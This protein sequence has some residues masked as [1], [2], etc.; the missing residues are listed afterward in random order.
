MF[1]QADI[2]QLKQKG[3]VVEQVNQQIEFFRKGIPKL[4]IDR[5]A[6]VDD[7]IIVLN[8]DYLKELIA[9]F[10]DQNS[11]NSVVKFVPASGAA[12]RMFKSLFEQL[13]KPNG[14]ELNTEIEQVLNSLPLFAFYDD[15]IEKIEDHGES[16]SI[17]LDI[18]DIHT[19]LDYILSEKGLNY[20]NLPK[21]L[22]KFHKYPLGNRTAVEEHLVEGAL[23]AKNNNEDV[24]IHFTVSP[25]HMAKFRLLINNLID[26]YNQHYHVKFSIDYSVQKSSTDTIAVNDQNEPFREKNGS[27]V[28]R[29]GGHGALLENLNDLDG[30]IVFIKNIDNVVVDRLK[31]TT[32]VYKKALA[33]LLLQTQ[34]Q[35]F[36]YESKLE[37]NSTDEQLLSEIKNFTEMWLGYKFAPSFEFISLEERKQIHKKILN[38]PIRVCGM[39]KNYD[40]PGGGP[41]WIKNTNGDFSL[42]ILESSQF[43]FTQESHKQ[44]F[45]KATHFNPV[46]LVISLRDVKGRKFK[47]SDFRDPQTGFISIKS[48]DGK[49]L[50]ALELPGLWNGAMANWNTIFVEVPIETFNPVKTVLDLLR[51]EHQ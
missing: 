2:E 49:E 7:G 51:K 25:E 12:T 20:G 43:D 33:G 5:P 44:I 6:I 36:L 8:P 24:K 10:D 11:N 27:L 50:K 39:V 34:K 32:V 42:Q 14:V 1:T 45:Q 48:K 4:N 46:D 35:I 9:E 13:A 40:Q 41:F 38:R 23:Y 19:I 30:D 29:P 3:L 31:D 28:F 17:L 21:G 22:I 37:R 16:L 18:G 15:L 47:F 26:K